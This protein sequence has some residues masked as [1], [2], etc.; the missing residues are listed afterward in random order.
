MKGKE[1]SGPF[2][3]TSRGDLVRGLWDVSL[4]WSGS[5]GTCVLCE[6]VYE[7]VSMLGASVCVYVHA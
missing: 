3:S 7:S 6:K 5:Y 2:R 4:W 1:S